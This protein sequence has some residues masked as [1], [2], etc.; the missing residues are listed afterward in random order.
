MKIVISGY[1]GFDN[2]GDEA[3][4]LAMIQAF[5]SYDPTIEIVV[6]SNSPETT[7]S[8]FHVDAVD[9][10]NI[11]E[12]VRALKNSDGLISGGGSLL[13]DE[14]GINSIIYYTGV[15][16]MAEFLG[17][18]VFIYAQ[19]MGPLKRTIAKHI[20][21]RALKKAKIT[22]RDYYSADLLKNIG[23]KKEVQI[24]PDPVLGLQ[25]TEDMGLVKWWQERAFTG[26]VV[27]VSVRDWPSRV[28]Y[29]QKIAKALDLLICEGIQVVFIPMHGKYDHQTSIEVA[30]MMK[31]QSHIA[32]HHISLEE[33]IGIIKQSD[34]L[35]G[36]RLHALIFSALT[37]TPFV[38]LSYDPKIDAFSQISEQKVVGHVTMNDWSTGSLYKQIL[39]TLNNVDNETKKLKNIIIPLQKDAVFTAKQAIQ[40]IE[41]GEEDFLNHEG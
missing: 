30:K 16:K 36:M 9:R 17:L 13:Q 7:K 18:P 12:I 22:I 3:I 1:Y 21:K 14:T 11:K 24:V 26:R 37:Y 2:V 31:G 33:K 10:W 28:G 15:I 19:G 38:A 4:L 5:R 39:N 40:F 23:I 41:Y 29:K 27:T 32:P 20:V 34:T 6:L 8:Q 35:M 25:V